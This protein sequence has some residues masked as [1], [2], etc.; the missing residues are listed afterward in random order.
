MATTASKVKKSRLGGLRMTGDENS[1]AVADWA[2]VDPKVLHRLVYLVTTMSERF[3]LGI[4]VMEVPIVWESILM[5][6]VRLFISVLAETL[7]RTLKI[8]LKR[9]RDCGEPCPD[10]QNRSDGL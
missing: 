8:L 2:S 6:I 9:L 4:L 7:I 1:S 5:M 10:D 3:G